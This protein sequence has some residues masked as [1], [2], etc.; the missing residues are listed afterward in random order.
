MSY[1][2]EIINVMIASPGDVENERRIVKEIVYEWNAIHSLRRK[3]ILLPVGWETHSFPVMGDRPQKIINSQVLKNC[4]LLVG[5]FWTRI[6]TETGSYPSGTVEE[7]EEHIKA[8]KPVMLY[9][10]NQPAHPDSIN[11]LQYEK[12]IAFKE[13]CRKNGLYET[14]DSISEFKE[15][16]FRQLQLKLNESEFFKNL[17]LIHNDTG[18]IDYNDINQ[19]VPDLSGEARLLLKEASKDKNGTILFLRVLG[20]CALQTNGKDF[21]ASSD[22]REIAKWESALY[23]LVSEEFVVERGYKG[24][25]FELTSKGYQFAD[26][27]N[28]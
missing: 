3:I 2:A 25:I 11:S 5:I 19:V 4:D 21:I 7:I 1:Q 8:D 15:K 24:E 6:G 9:F 23:Q 17:S 20:G 13:S 22:H 26:L 12:L 18:E 27:I 10:S 14:Y 16:F 28:T